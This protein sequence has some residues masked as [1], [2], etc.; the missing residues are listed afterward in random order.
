MI[1]DQVMFCVRLPKK[2]HKEAKSM[3]LKE[4]R[5]MQALIEQLIKE[6]LEK[7]K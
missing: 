3:V 4:D 6:Y 1:T 5:T 7:M 2:L